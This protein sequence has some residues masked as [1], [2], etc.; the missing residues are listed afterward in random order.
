MQRN[1]LTHP[2]HGFERE[3]PTVGS[4][5]PSQEALPHHTY[6]INHTPFCCPTST[7]TGDGPLLLNTNLKIGH[8][9][10]PS[11]VVDPQTL[12]NVSTN[13]LKNNVVTTVE[14]SHK[15]TQSIN[16]NYTKNLQNQNEN[17]HKNLQNEI[18]NINKNTQNPNTNK[19]SQ[20]PNTNKNTQNH[21][22][23]Y[24]KNLQNEN[25]KSC[26]NT[27]N[28]AE[29]PSSQELSI[30]A[31]DN[32][33]N[34]TSNNNEDII[35]LTNNKGFKMQINLHL[36]AEAL[37]R[38]F[39]QPT[40]LY[41]TILIKDK[42]SAMLKPWTQLG[43]S[44][45]IHVKINAL[46]G[47][48]LRPAAHIPFFRLLINGFEDT[49]LIDSGAAYTVLSK[50]YANVLR[51]EPEFKVRLSA[52]NSTSIR[53]LGA[54]TVVIHLGDYD[55][56]YWVLV[57]DID[58]NIIG[59][60]FFATFDI[61]IK[62]G[63]GY[64]KVKG[65]KIPFLRPILNQPNPPTLTD[66]YLVNVV[67][68]DDVISESST[69]TLRPTSDVSEGLDDSGVEDFEPFWFIGN[70]SPVIR[71]GAF[72]P[73]DPELLKAQLECSLKKSDPTVKHVDFRYKL[74]DNM[75]SFPFNYTPA[76]KDICAALVDSL[77]VSDPLAELQLSY[78]KY[79]LE[80][81][82]MA[83]DPDRLL[84]KKRYL[85]S[86]VTDADQLAPCRD[87]IVSDLRAEYPTVFSDELKYIDHRLVYHHI[88][89]VDGY[90]KPYC[91]P[92]AWERQ[93]AVKEKLDEMLAQG[94][95][96]QSTSLFAS[97]ILVV[98][99]KDGRIR[100]CVDYRNL[101]AVTIPDNYVLPRI[102][103]LKTRIQGKVFTTIDLKDGFMQIPIAEEDI[104][105]T[106]MSTQWGLYEYLRMPFGLRNAP[107]TF[108]RFMNTVLHRVEHQ[109][110]YI[111]DI[112]V[113]S[114]NVEDHKKHL[115]GVF[116][117]LAKYGL[118]INIEKSHFVQTHVA[119]LGFE[120]Y[121]HGYRPLESHT[122]KIK[123]FPRPKTKKELQ[124]FL[125]ALQYYRSHIPG[126]AMIAVPLYDLTKGGGRK[127]VWTDAC[128][129]AFI[130]L[131]DS[132]SDRCPLVPLKSG[133]DFALYTDASG[134]ACGAV[135]T[136]NSAVVEFYSKTFSPVEQRYSCH[137]REALAMVLAIL[138]FKHILLGIPFTLYTD[139]RSLQ[140]WFLRP[141]VNER[142]ARWI[143][144][145]QDMI[146]R[147]VHIDG[148][149]NVLAD[150]MSR[151][152]G[153][154][155]SSCE[156][157]HE[158]MTINAITSEISGED[159]KA[160]LTEEFIKSC[161]LL[162]EHHKIVDGYHYSLESGTPRLL[163][164]PEYQQQIVKEV[165]EIGHYGRNRTYKTIQKEYYWPQ[166]SKS[167]QLG[168]RS[169]D[170]CQ[171]YKKTRPAQRDKV[172]F[173]QTERFKTVHIDIVGPL[174]RSS[175]DRRY[176]LT[177]MDRFSRW[178][179]AVP[180]DDITAPEVTSKFFANWICRFG[181]PDFVVTDQGS[182][183]ESGLFQEVLRSLGVHK[184]RTTQYH[185]QANGLIERAHSTF[186]HSLK[187]IADKVRCWERALPA[188]LLAMR[189][190]VSNLGVSP[191]LVLYGEQ[192]S[193]PGCFLP[194]V[195]QPWKE[196]IWEFV[197]Q[198]QNDVAAI[199]TYLLQVDPTL[200]GGSF[201]E[202]DFP[203]QQAYLERQTM[204]DCLSEKMLGPYQVVSFRFP[205]VTLRTERGDK[206]YN[207]D[208]V[209]GCF[210]L[211]QPLPQKMNDG[212][213]PTLESPDGTPE[214][215]PDALPQI[216][217]RVAECG[218]TRTLVYPLT[219]DKIPTVDSPS[220]LGSNPM[221]GSGGET[222]SGRRAD[223]AGTR[224]LTETE[225]SSGKVTDSS[226]ISN[227]VDKHSV[228]I[229]NAVNEKHTEGVTGLGALD[230]EQQEVMPK[231]TVTRAGRQVR[232]P[233]RFSPSDY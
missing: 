173:P 228:L 19:N 178:F 49:A 59:A 86:V 141:P 128:E 28:I 125:G 50:K 112:I 193:L 12:L 183:F 172:P 175:N 145:I 169:C 16:Q 15:N 120:F 99:K 210:D 213:Y 23:N 140:W 208:L 226:V 71:Q 5:V 88:Q 4:H 106:A 201:K 196:S 8:S 13:N 40:N 108:Q 153:L 11:G 61:D 41:L 143:V 68:E 116:E 102:D 33:I 222:S 231:A 147:V 218:D 25:T 75:A 45:T 22:I 167:V 163:V 82:G 92:I 215:D 7:N 130:R 37:F 146:F 47:A 90:K 46:V 192:L 20:N 217:P 91:Y 62:M 203:Y 118:V 53:V 10:D 55:F 159:F 186:K 78:D 232:P 27:K 225:T 142:H 129:R 187:C 32:E 65:N 100:L 190:A 96:R 205:N 137:E 1:S 160:K 138:H 207:M 85:V 204:K 166:M 84:R 17:Y 168:V 221:P 79:C 29:F 127:F 48:K 93:E 60:E 26:D 94:I 179:E 164:P 139:H 43:G 152:G 114:E 30:Q 76:Q 191:A 101:N 117:R 31:N 180:L 3:S 154:S 105:K 197:N 170:I 69:D 2:Q 18:E 77:D 182:Q 109:F 174:P 126:L 155:K 34:K 51:L 151:P 224:D 165:H 198:L 200:R 70:S 233:V 115:Q 110:C 36:L 188:T 81:Y 133:G 107:P 206:T 98:P 67:S 66:Q 227:N 6:I 144:K 195:L 113:F 223:L 184:K 123:D 72:S 21:I 135:L 44:G 131:K 95:I 103:Q 171:K 122:L 158:T 157:L 121:E 211:P 24:T 104:G 136:Q 89:L 35:L 54:V 52:A 194:K 14:N 80:A 56:P 209:R 83:I 189:C 176:V 58:F 162:P 161:K 111:D 220:V 124:S 150:L 74:K 57:A 199:R 216:A 185:P 202:K 64:L 63:K 212:R 149:E 148:K 177:M 38:Y 119:Y 230:M 39:S 156:A 73:K 42:Y 181:C 87:Q 229:Q 9:S 134:L 97:P 214:M 132:I 219:L